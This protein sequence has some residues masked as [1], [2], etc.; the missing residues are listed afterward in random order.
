MLALT[1][2]PGIANSARVQEV[3]EPA[4]ER[5]TLLVQT[6]AIGVCGT[7]REI[8]QGGYGSAPPGQDFLILGHE[9]LGCVLEAPVGSGFA[10]GDLVVGIVRR[11]DPVPC[12]H[13]AVG[14]WD[15]CRNGLYTEH[16]IKQ[17]HG[18]GAERFRIAPH[19]AV[20][21]PPS[22][23][24][25]GV[26]LEPASVVAK[27][28][29]HIEK[30]GRR[31]AWHPRRVL[32]T[33]AGPIGLLAAMLGVQRGLEVHVLDQVTEGP[34]P[35]LARN[36]GAIYHHGSV[37]EA[38][39]DA[40]IVVECTG[41]GALVY[42]ILRETAPDRIVCLIGIASGGRVPMIDP[43]ALNR[44][45]V[46][47]NAVV[48]GTVNANRRHYEAAVA[49]LARADHGWL[50]RLIT[51]RVPYQQWQKALARQP[52]DVKTVMDFTMH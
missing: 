51:R 50:E 32:V 10:A 47:D 12:L 22:L 40:E 49:A 24:S 28:W 14:E 38:C 2:R 21:L 30:I 45:M 6:L 37:H 15:M 1:V 9:A 31:A 25:A 7:D 11:P 33:G 20:K 13:C 8:I 27:A 44:S 34:K 17:A 5:N 48:F 39:A 4:P 42:E 19:Y 35:A 46:L 23:Q 36:L 18:F 29:E 16:G 52:H 26:L 3:A 41:V 43:T